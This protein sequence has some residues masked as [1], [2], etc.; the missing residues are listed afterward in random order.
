M[1][2]SERQ[3]DLKLSKLDYSLLLVLEDKFGENAEIIDDIR[4]L[5]TS[6][7][8]LIFSGWI[9]QPTAQKE[10]EKTVRLFIRKYIKRYN[11]EID[12]LNT[13]F[14]KLMD[15]VKAYAKED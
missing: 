13:L 1:Q 7:N 4:E 9:S 8:E 10:V 12:D 3:K 15:R 5:S 6:L 14:D 2:L 11:L